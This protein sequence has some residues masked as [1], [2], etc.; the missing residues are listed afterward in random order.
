MSVL[1]VMKIQSGNEAFSEYP[2]EEVIRILQDVI[3]TMRYGED[4]YISK[5]LRDVNGNNVGTMYFEIEE[6]EIYEND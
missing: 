2:R 4:D 3:D 1:F 5:T 6:E